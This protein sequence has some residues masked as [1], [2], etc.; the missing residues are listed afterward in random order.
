V[1][2]EINLES[3]K[4]RAMA[5]RNFL[6]LPP[7]S[8]IS[9]IRTLP[10]TILCMWFFENTIFIEELLIYIFCSHYNIIGVARNMKIMNKPTPIAILTLSK[11]QYF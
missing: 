7:K 1:N 10:L 8:D 6:S 9:T 4:D 5:K 11:A 3:R 2:T